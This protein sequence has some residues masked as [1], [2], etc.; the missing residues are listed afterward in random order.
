MNK[1]EVYRLL[2]EKVNPEIATIVDKAH[3]ILDARGKLIHAKGF[4]GKQ[5][6]EHDVFPEGRIDDFTP[7]HLLR[8][9]HN[10]TST[11]LEIN[12]RSQTVLQ[13]ESLK[14]S[15]QLPLWRLGDKFQIHT[16]DPGKWRDLL[17]EEYQRSH[18]ARIEHVHYAQ[19]IGCAVEEHICIARLE[20]RLQERTMEL[21]KEL[22]FVKRFAY[23]LTPENAKSS[24][25]FHQYTLRAEDANNRYIELTI[26]SV[27]DERNIFFSAIDEPNPKDHSIVIDD[28]LITRCI[29]GDWK[30][31]AELA[32]EENKE[33]TR[34]EKNLISKYNL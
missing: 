7:L 3:K 27:F 17:D 11:S 21:R 28:L 2:E 31:F 5:Y 23:E 1:G 29:D 6:D 24:V 32:L 25:N 30:K 26:C 20:E 34:H 19:D 15:D 14:P 22:E 33:C 9:R 4:Q 8:Y 16:Y 13:I 10:D 18:P 12:V